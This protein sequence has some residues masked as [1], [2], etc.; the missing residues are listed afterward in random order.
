MIQR[1]FLDR[2]DAKTTRTTVADQLDFIIEALSYITQPAL[3]IAQ[4]AVSRTQV[5]LQAAVFE[6]VPVAGGN[7]RILHGLILGK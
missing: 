7:Y 1:L 2:I 3:S 6:T 4:M 5:A